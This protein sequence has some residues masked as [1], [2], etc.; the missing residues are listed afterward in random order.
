MEAAQNTC[1][2]R[3]RRG[4][5]AAREGGAKNPPRRSRGDGGSGNLLNSSVFLEHDVVSAA[6]PMDTVHGDPIDL[7]QIAG[8]EFR[9]S[10]GF[11]AQNACTACLRRGRFAALE[12]GAKNPPGG[13]GGMVVREIYLI[14]V[15]SFSITSCAPPS[16]MEV[17]DTSVSLAFF[18]SSGMVSAPQ[19]HM[20]ER[21]LL[22]VRPTLS[23]RLPA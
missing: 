12:G 13:A 3:P 15:F 6:R 8:S 11:A 17:A 4:R 5:F 19:L 9:R 20:V 1:T 7:I 21:T 2:A 23:F 22:R 10:Q 14:A 18:W 16:T